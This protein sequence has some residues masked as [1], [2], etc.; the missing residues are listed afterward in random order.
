MEGRTAVEPYVKQEREN[1]KTKSSVKCDRVRGADGGSFIVRRR[2][3]PAE[4]RTDL[5]VQ[6]RGVFCM[7]PP[8][9]RVRASSSAWERIYDSQNMSHSWPRLPASRM[10]AGMENS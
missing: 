9:R 7:R 8:L 3:R 5:M 10:S 1:K 2:R 6:R 4:I